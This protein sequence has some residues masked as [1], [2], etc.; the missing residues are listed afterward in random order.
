[1]ETITISRKEYEELRRKA[2]IDYELVGKVKR[3]L[4][5]LKHGRI[6]EW[7]KAS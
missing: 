5:D 7:K 3:S 6:R 4:E 1:M 2:E